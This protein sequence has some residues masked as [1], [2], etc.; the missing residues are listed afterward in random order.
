[1]PDSSRSSSSS[2]LEVVSADRSEAGRFARSFGVLLRG[3]VLRFR[4]EEF[5]VSEVLLDFVRSF[6]RLP[7][8][9]GLPL[10]SFSGRGFH[11]SFAL[12]D[13]LSSSSQRVVVRDDV[14][15]L[16]TCGRDVFEERL[17]VS[18]PSRSGKVLVVDRSGSVLGLGEWR[19][20]RQ[21]FLIKNLFDRGDFLHR[22]RRRKGGSR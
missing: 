20:D 5:L 8:T 1:M 2:G 13:M 18:S 17:L 12:L 11:P 15:W 4:R 16:F 10:G 6:D 9:V 14:A 22:E 7:F 21:R 3:S 19:R